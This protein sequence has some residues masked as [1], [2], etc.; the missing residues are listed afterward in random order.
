MSLTVK[1]ITKGQRG[2]IAYGLKGFENGTNSNVDPTFVFDFCTHHSLHIHHIQHSL[3]TIGYTV[4]Q[5]DTQTDI[6][7]LCAD[8]GRWLEICPNC[9]A[10]MAFSSYSELRQEHR[11]TNWKANHVLHRQFSS[12]T[13]C[14]TSHASVQRQFKPQSNYRVTRVITA[15]SCLR[16]PW[17]QNIVTSEV[18]SAHASDY[19]VYISLN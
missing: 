9:V 17:S 11:T 13:H 5:T 18:R 3:A 10:E 19:F 15:Y 16:E 14:N 12:W 4:R 8:R 1:Y 7:F 6:R 2:P